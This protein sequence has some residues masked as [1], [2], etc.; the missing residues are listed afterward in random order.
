MMKDMDIACDMGQRTDS[1]MPVS[2]VVRSLYQRAIE[3]GNMDGGQI[4]PMRLYATK[5]L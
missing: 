4:A 5:P 3:Q 1:P 2:D